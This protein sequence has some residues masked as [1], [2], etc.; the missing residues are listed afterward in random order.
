MKSA[1]TD[2]VRNRPAIYTGGG[3]YDLR[4]RKPIY[5]FSEVKYIDNKILRIPNVV[6]ESRLTI[7]YSLIATAF[8]L[9]IQRINDEIEISKKEDLFAKYSNLKAQEVR[10]KAHREHGMYED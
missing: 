5:D 7:P 10:W 6:N 2:A 8:G 9:S 3:C 4:M 1:F